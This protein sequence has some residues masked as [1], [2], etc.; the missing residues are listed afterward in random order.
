MALE[1]AAK[2]SSPAGVTVWR[3]PP[4][5]IM[6]AIL[7]LSVSHPASAGERERGPQRE[8]VSVE[9]PSFRLEAAPDYPAV[10]EIG[11]VR[12]ELVP[13]PIQ[14]RPMKTILLEQRIGF[15]TFLQTGATPVWITEAPSYD[16]EPPNVLFQLRVTN[17]L[18]KVLR[19]QGVAITF[20]VNGDL[21][22]T[23]YAQNNLNA[24][25]I[26][27]E[28]SW[29]GVLQG[30]KIETAQVKEP[31]QP[32][33]Q[34]VGTK[35]SAEAVITKGS[36]TLL[37]GLYDVITELDE[38]SNPKKRSNFEWVFAYELATHPAQA[39]QVR[40][41]ASVTAEQAAK[42]QGKHPADWT[43]GSEATSQ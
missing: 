16:L 42:L 14:A 4:V 7:V 41:K 3:R 2:S 23:D 1:R 28:K 35:P 15:G 18:G 8:P 32:A 30:P 5:G 6:A 11:G 31:A 26:L 39:H 38:A 27:P 13:G 25:I 20:A 36:G 17:H 24:Q 21:I 29:E 19:L 34:K 37:V 9:I 12:M 33:G 43:L 22:P 40:Y 10:R